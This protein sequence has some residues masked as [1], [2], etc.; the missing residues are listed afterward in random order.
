MAPPQSERRQQRLLPRFREA[1]RGYREDYVL[2]RS[3]P[4]FQRAL[5]PALSIEGFTAPAELSLLYHLS[6]ALRGPGAVIEIGSYLGRSTVVLAR[7][8]IEQCREPV[9]AVDPHTAA[10]GIADEQP[11]DTR[12]DF[13]RNLRR[14]GVESHVRLLHMTSKRASAEWPGDPVRMLFV[15]G[16]HSRE[17][18]LEDVHGW[19]SYLTR[20]CSVVFDDFLPFRGVR[21]AVREL[22]IEGVVTGVGLILGKMVAFGPPEVMRS[23]PAPPGARMLSRL[24]D[25]PLDFAIRLLASRA[26]DPQESVSEL[27]AHGRGADRSGEVPG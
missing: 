14:A 18:V 26:A 27:I 22:R 24:G 19:A 9:V 4:A 17:A 10:L 1:I 6:V 25:R 8:A 23:L 5:E 15:D 16:W 11:R 3:D 21:A 13:V 20:E 12:A 2:R 7:A